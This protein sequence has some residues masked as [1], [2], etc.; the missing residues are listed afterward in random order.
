VGEILPDL[1]TTFLPH[2]YQMA[3]IDGTKPTSVSLVQGKSQSNGWAS[4]TIRLKES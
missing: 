4:K 3:A 1:I 2:E